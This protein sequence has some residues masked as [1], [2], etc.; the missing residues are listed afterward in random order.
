MK[1]EEKKIRDF[2]KKKLISEKQIFPKP[3]EKPV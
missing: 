1:R 3:K 2:V